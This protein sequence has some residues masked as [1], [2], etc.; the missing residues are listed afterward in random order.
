[1]KMIT[2]TVLHL[3]VMRPLWLTILNLHVSNPQKK[4]YYIV[5]II[6]MMKLSYQ[7]FFADVL[8][9]P[10]SQLS[11]YQIDFIWVLVYILEIFLVRT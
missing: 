5:D 1:M 6:I 7:I 9:F 4:R 2:K 8:D 3:H 10:K 11:L